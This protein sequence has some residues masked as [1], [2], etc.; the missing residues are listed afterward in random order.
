MIEPKTT[1]FFG[2]YWHGALLGFCAGVTFAYALL[3]LTH[4]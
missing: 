4:G 3:R 1:K 2:S